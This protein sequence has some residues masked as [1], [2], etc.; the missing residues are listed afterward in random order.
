MLKL[1]LDDSKAKDVNIFI[2]CAGALLVF[3]SFFT[4][5]NIQVSKLL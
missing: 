2:L 4:M 3:S 1:H 5:G